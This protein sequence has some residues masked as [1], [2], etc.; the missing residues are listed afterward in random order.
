MRR[1]WM[2]A[3]LGAALAVLL[4][5]LTAKRCSVRWGAL[6]RCCSCSP[7]RS[8]GLFYFRAK[9]RADEAHERGGEP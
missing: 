2:A 9:L 6:P 8:M 1:W 5:P 4:L 3:L 7:R